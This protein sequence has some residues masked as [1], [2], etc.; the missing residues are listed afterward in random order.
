MHLDDGAIAQT[1][2]TAFFPTGDEERGECGAFELDPNR[3]SFRTQRAR[4]C[5]RKTRKDF[6][7][8][9]FGAAV[10]G[11]N[12]TE[13]AVAIEEASGLFGSKE[14]VA[15]AVFVWQKPS[16]T[17]LVPLDAAFDKR[18][19]DREGIAPAGVSDK[20]ALLDEDAHEL[21]QVGPLG[22]GDANLHAEFFDFEDSI[23]VF[24]E[25]RE[26]DISVKQDLH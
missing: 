14:G 10:G 22:M 6:D 23:G 18:A 8:F 4:Q 1:F 19:F 11:G 15:H 16:E 21:S 12:A 26:D 20:V 24:R 25:R 9:A 2:G 5:A 3:I 17:A 13:D 7:D